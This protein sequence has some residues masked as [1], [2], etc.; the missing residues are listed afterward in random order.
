MGNWIRIGKCNNCGACCLTVGI[1][2]MLSPTSRKCKYIYTE[3]EGVFCEIR[4][5]VEGE[6]NEFL[7][8]IPEEDLKYW[9]NECRDYPDPNELAHLPPWHNLPSS[10]SY[11]L[12]EE[13]S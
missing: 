7:E 12:K 13:V 1:H 10:C 11:E 3:E 9:E 5:A 6:D 2:H 8:L 4:Q